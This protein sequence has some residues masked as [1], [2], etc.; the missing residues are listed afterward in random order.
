MS[1]RKLALF[2]IAACSVWA[3]KRPLTHQDY[4]SWRSILSPTLSNDGH[5]LAYGL[6]PQ[7]G[8]GVVVVRDM[9]TGH[10]WRENAGALPPPPAPD[11]NSED[12]A[13][14]VRT[15]RLAFTADSRE[16]VYLSYPSKAAV[17]EAKKQKKKPEEM[18]RNDLVAIDL[19]SGDALRVPGVKSFGVPDKTGGFL[20][21]LK[22][23]AAGTKKDIGSDLILR[24]FS[25]RTDRA[26]SDVTEFSL[27]RD[28][29]TL[30]YAVSSPK[31]ETDGLYALETSGGDSRALLSG[32][33]KYARIAWDENQ[34]QAAFISDRDDSASKEPHYKVYLWKVKAP[35]AAEVVS[36]ATPGFHKGYVISDKAAVTFT[37]DGSA[38]FFGAGPP[39]L[40]AP[41]E[42]TGPATEDEVSFD[43]WHYKDDHIQPMQKV[44][45]TVDGGRSYRAMYRIASKKFIQLADDTM[46]DA[47]PSDDARYALGGDDREYR[48]MVEYSER[49]SDAYVIDTE[50][51]ARRLI[52]K[53][54]SGAPSWS[55]NGLHAV[56]FDGKDWLSISMTSAAEPVNL[57]AK[58]GVK[59]WNEETDTPSTPRPYGLAGWTSDG[60][61]VLA[62]DRFDLWR[63]AADGSSAVDV[64]NGE[65][66]RQNL[67]FR[68][69]N[70]D[71]EEKAID[72]SKPLLLRAESP[73]TR[74][75]GFF[76]VRLPAGAQSAGP[77]KLL[78]AARDFGKPVKAKNADVLVFT[79]Q[80]FDEF[81]DLLATDSAMKELRKIT[82]ANPQKADLLWGTAEMISFK[83]L[84][85]V[86]LQG[87]L[88]KPENFDPN[89]KY[90]M[91]VYI[92]ERLSQNV[93]HFVDPRPMHTINFSYY[94]SNGYLVFTPDIVYTTGYPG[95]SALKCVMAGVDAI[96]ARGFVDE[97]NIGIE[98]H[99][100]GGYQ[101]AYMVTQTTRFTA[102]EAGAPVANMTSAY[103][104]IRWG[105]GLPRQFQ[106]EKTQSRIGG[107]LWEY[108]MRF[109]ENS[110]VFM[111]DRIKTPM[112]ILHND[113]DDAV[114][115]YQGIELFLALRRL[116]KEAYMFSY[117]GEPHGIRHR[118][119]QK[120][121][122]MRMSQFFDYEL[123]GAK[124]PMW[125][126]KGIPY[127]E[128][129]RPVAE[130]DQQ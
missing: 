41:R 123:K 45:A 13:P 32:K 16:L 1:C 65:G 17:D 9:K 109:I 72:A 57:T 71:P 47:V 77:E 82:D 85:G 69:V 30:L 84:D 5:F 79:G 98:G 124:K 40:P 114:P 83:N 3:A 113:M 18:P 53:K 100:W 107:S 92:Y 74:D 15:I 23:P 115:W 22:E 112:L 50:T 27:S 122:A 58:L 127:L 49:Y 116:G 93:N 35:Q 73:V 105:P 88:Y 24:N 110:P 99:S 25:T 26:F 8:D 68:Y 102:V 95:Q 90:P 10:E 37:K 130:A 121:F 55:P 56:L 52:A 12:P 44:R 6:F 48:P 87:V 75:T 33:G 125:M 14:P 86:P 76:R 38:I 61:Y 70:L 19:T 128:K 29:N 101:I 54:H 111:A 60:K 7:E 78:L 2:F 67:E 81:P 66:R 59:F 129:G 104:G 119:N 89:R 63:I 117:N 46:T 20:A 11:P 103:D 51:G 126:E 80:T 64:T 108:P 42:H 28:G 120:D 118:A 91:I 97:K 4:D 39:A 43:L 62:Y 94:V 36:T 34:T 31:E 106:Y 21:Y 96:V